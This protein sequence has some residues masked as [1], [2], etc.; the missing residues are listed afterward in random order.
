MVVAEVDVEPDLVDVRQRRG[1]GLVVVDEEVAALPVAA[2]G[3]AHVVGGTAGRQHHRVGRQVRAERLEEQVLAAQPVEVRALLP[4]R[5]ERGPEVVVAQ[6]QVVRVAGRVRL[7]RRR[8]L[9]EHLGGPVV[10]VVALPRGAAAELGQGERRDVV[11]VH[12]RAPVVGDL[13]AAAQ[14]TGG[15]RPR[16]G[17]AVRGRVSSRGRDGGVAQVGA[18]GEVVAHGAEH[19]VRGP[20]RGPAGGGLLPEP[21]GV[22]RVH[23]QHTVARQ[24]GAAPPGREPQ[25]HAQ[26][27]GLREV[28]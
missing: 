21:V 7:L 18:H 10:E 16:V 1:G 9:P 25:R 28:A 13:H 24:L 23:R 12:Q 20:E 11:G 8:A 27:G 3:P 26:A 17:G 2:D 6:R 15:E 4:R 5:P 14:L 22:A 19:V